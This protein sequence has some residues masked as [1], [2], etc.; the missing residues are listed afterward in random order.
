MAVV[1]VLEGGVGEI[2]PQN[3]Q[4]EI[5]IRAMDMEPV[6]QTAVVNALVCTGSRP[7]ATTCILCVLA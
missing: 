5:S 7:I 1:S 2:V 6:S 3:A 4:A